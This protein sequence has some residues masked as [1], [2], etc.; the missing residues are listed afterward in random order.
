MITLRKFFLFTVICMVVGLQ[1]CEQ[2]A[3]R[4]DNR[5]RVL[6]T[7]PP[8]YSFTKNIAG[9]AASVDNLLPSGAGPHEYS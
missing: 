9:D 7:I 5:L 3:S 2:P 1:A 4:T 8:L 6:T